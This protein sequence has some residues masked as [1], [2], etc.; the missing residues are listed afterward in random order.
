MGK[1]YQEAKHHTASAMALLEFVLSRNDI[2]TQ[3]QAQSKPVQFFDVRD[4]SGRGICSFVVFYILLLC[5]LDYLVFGK[6][7][8]IS[9]S[10]ASCL[11]RH[12]S[13]MH[14]SFYPWDDQ[15][16]F[17]SSFSMGSVAL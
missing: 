6:A 12:S 14:G 1:V 7:D 11:Y 13:R 16:N 15:S 3:L 17:S 9:T 8:E 2:A 10:T 4:A 5:I